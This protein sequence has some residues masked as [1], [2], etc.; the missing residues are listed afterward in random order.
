MQRL[1]HLNG[2]TGKRGGGSYYLTLEVEDLV[3]AG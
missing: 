1:V 2:D 3:A